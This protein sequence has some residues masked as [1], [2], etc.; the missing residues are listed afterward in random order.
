MKYVELI[1]AWVQEVSYDEDTSESRLHVVVNINEQ[2][3]KVFIEGDENRGWLS[4]Y[5]YAPFN[6]KKE[7][8]GDLLK[9]INRLNQNTYFGK[10]VLLDDGTIQ[11]KQIIGANPETMTTEILER[12]YRTGIAVYEHWLDDIASISLTKTTFAAWEKS[13]AAEDDQS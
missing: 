6:C 8:F 5:M 2:A 10:M 9:L 11:Y 12:M 13:Q 1:K 7:K 4:L 3:V